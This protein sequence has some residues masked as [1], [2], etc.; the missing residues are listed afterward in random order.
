MIK[1]KPNKSL[2]NC[3]FLLSVIGQMVIQ[4]SF[5]ILYFV[6]FVLNRVDRCEVMMD[7]S[8][9]YITEPNIVNSVNMIIN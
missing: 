1:D 2:L 6:F 8:G 9:E 3:K 4:T 5:Q 7:E